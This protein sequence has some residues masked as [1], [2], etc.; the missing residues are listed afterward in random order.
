METPKLQLAFDDISWAAAIDLVE[1]LEHLLDVVEVG[2]P[3]L[4]RYGLDV[5]KDLTGRQP[6]L[7]VLCDANI[8]DA[9]FLE[10]SLAFDDGADIV[11]VLG[12][13]DDATIRGAV[14]AARAHGGRVMADLLNV[15]TITHRARELEAFGVDLIAVHRQRPADAGTHST[16][17]PSRA[18]VA[19]ASVR[20]SPWPAASRP[21]RHSSTWPRQQRSSL[22][23]R[24]SRK[25]LIRWVRPLPFALSSISSSHERHA[26]PRSNP[27]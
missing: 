3:M 26:T 24:P 8:A 7:Q 14:D 19:A 15:S 4:L 5:V 27:G 21:R 12:L 17:G 6:R 20:R 25:G 9:A 10:A 22:S 18:F 23:V 11:T 2:T 16:T 1:M 13:S